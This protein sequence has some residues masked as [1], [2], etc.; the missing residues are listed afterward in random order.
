MRILR[1]LNKKSYIED[2]DELDFLDEPDY[3]INKKRNIRKINYNEDTDEETN[4]E[5][6]ETTEPIKNN[7]RKKP[8]TESFDSTTSSESEYTTNS[9]TDSIDTNSSAEK[10]KQYLN[11]L[12]NL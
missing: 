10:N 5:I 8:R 12:F 6:N 3:T 4:E 7:K 9:E 11:Y 1:P 2:N